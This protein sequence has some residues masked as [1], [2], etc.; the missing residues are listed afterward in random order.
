[1]RLR[2]QASSV[3]SAVRADDTAALDRPAD[4]DTRA[5]GRSVR[6]TAV[7]AYSRTAA[8]WRAQRVTTSSRGTLRAGQCFTFGT[9]RRSRSRTT[10]RA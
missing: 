4:L 7:A 9:H 5:Y 8:F 1:M 6:A 10:M 3:P 2:T